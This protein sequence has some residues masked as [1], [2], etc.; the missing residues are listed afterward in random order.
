MKKCSGFLAEYFMF[1]KRGFQ[2]G[3]EISVAK[4]VLGYESEFV[5]LIDKL[6]MTIIEILLHLS[7][8]NSFDVNINLQNFLLT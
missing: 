8:K 4:H 5:S 2:I 1:A 7:Y 6:F 3:I